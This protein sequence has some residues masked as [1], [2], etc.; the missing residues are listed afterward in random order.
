[1]TERNKLLLRFLFIVFFVSYMMGGF[2][3][4]F[5]TAFLVGGL[6]TLG[7]LGLFW[8]YLA[9]TEDQKKARRWL[10]LFLGICLIVLAYVWLQALFYNW[11][12]GLFAHQQ[13]GKTY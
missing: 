2:A 5:I 9:A 3:V 12:F 1:M 11:P 6:Y 10:N 13:G 7:S 4:D 8:I